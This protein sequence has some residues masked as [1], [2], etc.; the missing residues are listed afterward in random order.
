MCA[1]CR[2]N[3]FGVLYASPSA[4]TTL[5]TGRETRS[6]FRLGHRLISAQQRPSLTSTSRIGTKGS[7]SSSSLRHGSWSDHTIHPNPHEA[8]KRSHCSGGQVLRK[9]RTLKVNAKLTS[10]RCPFTTTPWNMP[11]FRYSR[12]LSDFP[13]FLRKN[14]ETSKHFPKQNRDSAK[15]RSKK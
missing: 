8:T 2:Q 3:V 6:C 13:S 4:S 15:L 1:Q 14:P 12:V 5:G 9:K 7:R 10:L 11:A